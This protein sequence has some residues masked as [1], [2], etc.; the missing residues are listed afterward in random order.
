MQQWE[1]NCTSVAAAALF[2]KATTKGGFGRKSVQLL[3]DMGKEGWELVAAVRADDNFG[4]TT[5]YFKRPLVV[6]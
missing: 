5:L 6:G 2:N 1:Y 3:D 4:L